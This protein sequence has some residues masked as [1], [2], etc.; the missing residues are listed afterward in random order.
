MVALTFSYY[1]IDQ[2][3]YQVSSERGTLYAAPPVGK[4]FP[5]AVAFMEQCKRSFQN[6]VIMETGGAGFVRYPLRELPEA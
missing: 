5:Q 2:R 3:T 1:P 4:P 6:V